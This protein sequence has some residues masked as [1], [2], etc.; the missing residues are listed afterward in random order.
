MRS[1]FGLFLALAILVA[2]PAPLRAAPDA[3]G[4]TQKAMIALVRLP[5]AEFVRV[6]GARR[7]TA[8]AQLSA[9]DD[10][11]ARRDIEWRWAAGLIDYAY[12]HERETGEAL[13]ADWVP[14]RQALTFARRGDAAALNSAAY[15]QYLDAWL[16]DRS[17]ALLVREPSFHTG[18]NRSLRANFAAIASLKADRAVTL[19]L[20]SKTLDTHVDDNGARGIG[21]QIKALAAAG[22]A[23]ADIARLTGALADDEAPPTD[24]RALVYKTV[25]GVDLYAHVFPPKETTGPRPVLFWFHGGS[26]STGHWSYCPVVCRAMQSQGFVVIQVEYRTSQRFDG[27]PLDALQDGRDVIAWAQS[28]AAVLGLDPKRMMT[29]GFS[30]GAS[31]GSQLAV[32]DS[33]NIRGGAFISGCYEPAADSF[34]ARKVSPITDP[35]RL[36]PLLRLDAR[37][38]PLA[39]F[40]AKDDEMCPYPDAAAMADRAAALGVATRLYSFDG[41]GHFFVFGSPQVKDQ[42]RQGLKTYV[43]MLGWDR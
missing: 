28:N 10:K 33:D 8:V 27:T 34:Y 43:T 16:H 36:S 3:S 22:G 25:D 11:A 21:P 26:W 42:I 40:H 35:K 18:D 9:R 31:L 37:S 39:L 5:P 2:D 20:L 24:H 23:P 7:A 19:Y 4:L 30:S 14:K 32:L 13:P 6:W 29:A 17:A 1:L 38:P 12:F 15:I 41:G